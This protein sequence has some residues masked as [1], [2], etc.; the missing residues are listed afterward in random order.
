MV[1]RHYGCEIRNEAGRLAK[2]RITAS[3]FGS[4]F[5]A[6]RAFDEKAHAHLTL[7]PACDQRPEVLIT[8]FARMA[9]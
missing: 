8:S 5:I 2:D 9:S 7:P 3:L 4:N 1:F 6:P